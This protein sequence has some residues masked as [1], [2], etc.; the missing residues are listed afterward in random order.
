MKVRAMVGKTLDDSIEG[1]LDVVAR[2]H[3]LGRR[4]ENQGVCEQ[5]R[6]QLLLEAPQSLENPL[7]RQ[8]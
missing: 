3:A 8:R 5:S 7:R 4:D 6:V 2:P 1:K